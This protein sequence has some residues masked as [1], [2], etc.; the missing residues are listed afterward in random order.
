MN[1]SGSTPAE[2]GTAPSAQL[3]TVL[4]GALLAMVLAALDQNIVNTALPR[5]VGD[6]GGMAHLSWVV[7]AFMLCSTITTPIYGKLSDIYGRR[8]LFFVAI[9][10]FMA[11]SLAC[12][13]AQSMGQLIG[14]R[15]LQG[16]GAGGL[17]VLAQAAI[18]DVVSPR[19]RPRYQGLFT[20]TFALSSVAGPLLGGVITQA[21]NWR[22]V[23]YVNLPVGVL[24]LVM[25]AIG[26]RRP[27]SGKRRSI[28]YVGTVLLAGAHRRAAAAAGL[29]RHRVSLAVAA[30]RRCWLAARRGAVRAC[31]SGGRPAR[32]SR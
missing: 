14:F 31:S 30:T 24:A 25:I 27:P 19:D 10:V 9:L 20:G 12:G 11:G 7:T 3:H 18:G 29:G 13:A 32:R 15:A 23:F 21:F 16:L 22:W 1:G 5:I 8:T 2:P 28:D 4:A 17:L 6:L 26:L